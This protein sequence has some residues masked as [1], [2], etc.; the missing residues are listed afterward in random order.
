MTRCCAGLAC[1]LVRLFVCVLASSVFGAFLFSCLVVCVFAGGWG[2]GGKTCVPAYLSPRARQRTSSAVME[3]RRSDGAMENREIGNRIALLFGTLSRDYGDTGFQK[4]PS[5]YFSHCSGLLRILRMAF[6][7][8]QRS[9]TG[10][11]SKFGTGQGNQRRLRTTNGSDT[12]Q[13]Q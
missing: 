12:M 13:T 2:V 9:I 4:L 1:L 3:E 5:Y 8:L 10:L 11:Q 7:V 6:R